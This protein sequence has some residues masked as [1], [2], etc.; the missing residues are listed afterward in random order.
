MIWPKVPY[1]TCLYITFGKA[2]IKNW[3]IVWCVLLDYL[4]KVKSIFPM[5]LQFC[6]VLVVHTRNRFHIKISNH[7]SI[8][9]VI[10][11]SHKVIKF[12]YQLLKFTFWWHINA[13]KLH[14]DWQTSVLHT[15]KYGFQIVHMI[16]FGL[17]VSWLNF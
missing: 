9:C 17:L 14:R 1:D 4:V 12:M 10:S 11:I 7:N 6:V 8:T 2:Q 16:S 5:L 13:H 3:C 15:N